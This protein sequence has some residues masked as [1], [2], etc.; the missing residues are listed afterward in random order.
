MVFVFLL[1]LFMLFSF[2]VYFVY[3]VVGSGCYPNLYA[4]LWLP[5]ILCELPAMKIKQ[6]PEDFQVEELTEVVPGGEG[7]YGFYRL[8]KRSWST[9]DALA[10]I[11]RRWKVAPGRLSYGGLKDRHAWTVQYFTLFHGPRR[12]LHHQDVTVDYLGQVSQ[13]YTSANIQA[14]RFRLNLRRLTA[15][16]IGRARPILEEVEVDGVPNYFDDQR[17]R[18][19]GAG[20][21][22]IARLLVLGRFE[23][24]LQLA[25]AA[26]YEHDRTAAKQ[27]KALLQAHWGD[28]EGLKQRLP[29]GH[30]RSLV[31]YLLHH[32]QDFRGAVSRLRPELRGLYLSAYQSH[33]WN[34]MLACWIGDHCRS[35]QV[36]PVALKLG[37]LP[38]W[39]R[40]DTAQRQELRTLTLPLPSARVPMADDERGR[41]LRGVLAEEGLEPSQMKVKGIREMFFSKGERPALCLPVHLDVETSPD[42]LHVGYEK[43]HLGFELPRGSYATLIVKRL[44]QS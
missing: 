31:D 13:P 21:E 23:D 16:E 42:E 40:L 10:A 15:A 1:F 17:F 37:V 14:N 22:F 36:L 29:R 11:R 20:G 4:P 44:Q 25:L 7:P 2:F 12:G 33:L 8:E 18:S 35:E 30:A 6:Q 5:M 19:V 39:R 27:E 3:F 9:P 41:L 32:P 43:L 38:M 34:R 26:P 24:A 28:W